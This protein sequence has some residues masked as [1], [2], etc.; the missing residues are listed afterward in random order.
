MACFIA[1]RAE[2]G[3]RRAW[4]KG[5]KRCFAVDRLRARPQLL[6]ISEGISRDIDGAKGGNYFNGLERSSGS[7]GKTI[8]RR[9]HAS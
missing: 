1:P 7:F 3:L 2:E 4:G 5:G 8:S 6:K 9:G